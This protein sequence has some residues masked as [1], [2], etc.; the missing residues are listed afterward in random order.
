MKNYA[1][2]VL[3][4]L[5]TALAGCSNYQYKNYQ[6]KVD[7][8]QIIPYDLSNGAKDAAVVY[9]D[10]LA[11]RDVGIPFHR[12]LLATRVDGVTLKNAGRFSIL[13]ISGY[14]ALKLAP[15]EHSLEWCWVSM[16]ALGTGGANCGFGAPKVV[17]K[18]NKRYL[19]TWSTYGEINGPPGRQQHTLTI[20][21]N[22]QDM[23][24]KE[25]VFPLK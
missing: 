5:L 14:Q 10:T 1:T 19:A 20:N 7:S 15:G 24:N 22:I 6:T 13:D 11:Y 25:V 21:T 8:D 23:D 9:F 3:V 18:P 2:L 17:L 4:S 12:L 16:N